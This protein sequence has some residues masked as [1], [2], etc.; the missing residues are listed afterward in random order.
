VR[1]EPATASNESLEGL[2]YPLDRLPEAADLYN[3]CLYFDVVHLLPPV[4]LFLSWLEGLLTSIYTK[5]LDLGQQG[6][7]DALL[8]IMSQLQDLQTSEEAGIDE[9]LRL[10]RSLSDGT[11]DINYA[12]RLFEAAWRLRE[13]VDEST[14]LVDA[15]I[16]SVDQVM[17][18]S[19]MLCGEEVKNPHFFVTKHIGE[20]LTDLFDL[21][22]LIPDDLS[23]PDTGTERQV[24]ERIMGGLEQLLQEL[25]LFECD[26][27]GRVP[28]STDLRYLLSLCAANPRLPMRRSMLAGRLASETFKVQLPRFDFRDQEQV[29]AVRNACQPHLG[30]FRREMKRCAHKIRGHDGTHSLDE[31]EDEIAGIMAD[32]RASVEELR[33]E[34]GKA[35]DAYWTG[36]GV[37]SA[38]YAVIHASI[39]FDVELYHYSPELCGVFVKLL[40]AIGVESALLARRIRD[41][42]RKK[43]GSGLG[44]VVTLQDRL[45]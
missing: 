27:M 11:P 17:A 20:G 14:A 25:V 37:R 36:L 42:R 44:Y 6:D 28:F 24:R 30:A 23:S 9:A 3:Y 29:V 26:V 41:I 8:R 7:L 2:Y 39:Q 1:G 15:G 40:A 21:Q 32:V 33:N 18:S 16:L 4:Q 22:D 5:V 13:Y 10:A 12:M 38:G 31:V 43:L 19:A 35:W 45:G 34:L